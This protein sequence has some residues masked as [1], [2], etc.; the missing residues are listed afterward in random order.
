MPS[1]SD[2]QRNFFLAVLNCKTT[3]RCSSKLKK[4]ADSMSVQSI[5]DFTKK[6]TTILPL[7][8]KKFMNEQSINYQSRNP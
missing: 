6:E 2:A 8:F 5:K 1:S 4:T 7:S 3:G